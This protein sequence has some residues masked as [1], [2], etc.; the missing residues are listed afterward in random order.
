MVAI[1]TAAKLL[2]DQGDS[3]AQLEYGYYLMAGKGVEVDS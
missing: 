1:A 3:A 2:A